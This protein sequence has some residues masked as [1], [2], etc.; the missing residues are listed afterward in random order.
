MV[1]LLLP[2]LGGAVS[3]ASSSS[4]GLSWLAA[5]PLPSNRHSSLWF[6]HIFF[7]LPFL[8]PLQLH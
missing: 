7:H 5:L 2:A 6:C 4:H 8:P 1:F 3:L